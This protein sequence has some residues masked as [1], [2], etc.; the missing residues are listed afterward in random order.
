MQKINK[1]TIFRITSIRYITL[2]PI[3]IFVGAGIAIYVAME[4][5]DIPMS[6][7]IGFISTLLLNFLWTLKIVQKAKKTQNKMIKVVQ[8]ELQKVDYYNCG[9]YGALAIDAKEKTIATVCACKKFKLQKPFVFHFDKIDSYKAF[10]PGFSTIR[11]IGEESV[12]NVAEEL[13]HNI[14]SQANANFQSGLYFYLDDITKPE[15]FVQ[16]QYGEAEKWMLILKKLVDGSL[17]E[18]STPFLF[19][20]S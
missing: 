18:Q 9:E 13:S 7:L 3:W 17:E 10:A 5:K 4:I 11:S 20:Q 1:R 16:M 12:F 15:I 6:I 14:A 8:K 2:F 19:P